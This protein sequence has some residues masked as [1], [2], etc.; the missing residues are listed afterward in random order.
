LSECGR[1]LC[2]GRLKVTYDSALY[3]LHRHK[4]D[5][6]PARLS[7]PRFWI[8]QP[9]LK[10]GL[11][12]WGNDGRIYAPYVLLRSYLALRDR[13][14]LTVPDD[15]PALIAAV[16]DDP[17][18]IPPVADPNLAQALEKA[19]GKMLED[20]DKQETQARGNLI[21]WPHDE[22]V[23]SMRNKQLDEDNPEL[24][25]TWRAL[26]RLARPS[27]TLVC[28]HRQA[29]GR[30]TLEPE[31]QTPVDLTRQPDRGLAIEL[32]EHSVAVSDYRV[33]RHF[34][35]DEPPAGWLKNASLR[36]YRAAIFEQGR[37]ECQD[38]VLTL[39]RQRG[40]IIIGRSK[41]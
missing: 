36:Y 18:T 32:W 20:I 12:Q 25:E 41:R 31:G 5:E 23:F 7:T 30:L 6:R 29:D 40:L 3:S 37:C 1:R 9:D 11:P 27:I 19:Y 39:D 4:R 35:A 38:A 24:H 10:E 8:L 22:D 15:V 33:V 26:T 14:V 34:L 28:L 13:E 2:Q 21:A 16:Y 17:E